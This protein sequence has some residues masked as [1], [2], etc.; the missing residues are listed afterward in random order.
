MRYAAYY[1]IAKL[2]YLLDDYKTVLENADLLIKNDYDT[3]DG[4]KFIDMAN[5]LKN[6][7]QFYNIDSRQALN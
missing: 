1:N 6:Q 5:E 3:S 4:E 7:F 2:S